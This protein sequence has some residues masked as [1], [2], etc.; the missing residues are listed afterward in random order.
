MNNSRK[1]AGEIEQIRRRMHS[2][3]DR[4]GGDYQNPEVQELAAEFDRAMLGLAKSGPSN[5]DSTDTE[6][7][8]FSK[9]TPNVHHP[10]IETPRAMT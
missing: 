4:S 6:Q 5:S 3:W 2:A 8:R 9:A 7:E 1:H 10:K